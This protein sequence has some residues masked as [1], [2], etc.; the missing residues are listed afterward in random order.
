MYETK[1]IIL[2]CQL[3]CSTL[4]IM[5]AFLCLVQFYLSSRNADD[6]EVCL[7]PQCQLHWS[8]YL[9]VHALAPENGTRT[10]QSTAGQPRSHRNQHRYFQDYERHHL[11][12][13][14]RIS[15]SCGCCERRSSDVFSVPTWTPVFISHGLNT[16]AYQ[17]RHRADPVLKV[18]VQPYQKV[19]Y[20]TRDY[21]SLLF[22]SNY[23]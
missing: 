6:P 22:N 19:N 2:V 20:V 13:L 21:D 23:Y 4:H 14:K 9:S 8:T 15:L 11:I 12:F 5:F 18:T 7:Q 16:S 1:L 17:S 3:C 10:P